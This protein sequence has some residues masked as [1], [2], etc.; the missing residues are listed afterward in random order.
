MWHVFENVE[1]LRDG[2]ACKLINMYEKFIFLY[3]PPITLLIIDF[4]VKTHKL[5]KL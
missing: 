5:V 3:S 1:V 2:E 4:D